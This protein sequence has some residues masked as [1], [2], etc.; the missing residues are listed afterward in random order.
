MDEQKPQID[1]LTSNDPATTAADLAPE[2]GAS[3]EAAQTQGSE[4]SRE[5]D[6][7]KAQAAVVEPQPSTKNAPDQ[8]AWIPELKRFNAFVNEVL[9][10]K[11]TLKLRACDI[12]IPPEFLGDWTL[13]SN[14]LFIL[15]VNL[16]KRLKN[17]TTNPDSSLDKVA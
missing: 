4:D 9:A 12:K 2:T 16:K 17:P 14:R 3:A 5:A 1:N 11:E 8:T 15:A 10:S 13:D 7:K 6:L